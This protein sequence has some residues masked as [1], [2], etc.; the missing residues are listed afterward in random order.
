MA[1]DLERDAM[2]AV[3]KL[4]LL[5]FTGSSI[6][7]PAL[8]DVLMYG[9]RNLDMLDAVRVFGPDQ[10]EAVRIVQGRL[11]H[12]VS[13]TLPDVVQAIARWSSIV[14]HDGRKLG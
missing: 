6:G 4:V 11:V 1:T 10:A 12:E 9:R 7:D 3:R 2:S 8:P 13:G 5:G 14:A